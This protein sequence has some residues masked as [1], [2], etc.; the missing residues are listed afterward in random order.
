MGE[1]SELPIGLKRT[2]GTE[3]RETD[4]PGSGMSVLVV[5]G[6]VFGPATFR[7]RS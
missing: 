6:T 5:A 2:I 1:I 7:L 3:R 4:T